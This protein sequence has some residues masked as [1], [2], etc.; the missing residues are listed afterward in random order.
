MNTQLQDTATES[1]SGHKKIIPPLWLVIASAIAGVWS[2]VLMFMGAVIT[3]TTSD[4][5]A[6]VQ[7]LTGY[8]TQGWYI[9]PSQLKDGAPLDV[10]GDEHVYAPIAALFGHLFVWLSGNASDSLPVAD[11]L[12]SYMARHASYGVLAIVGAVALGLMI[13]KALKSWRWGVLAGAALMALPTW[14]GHGMFN[15]KD[16][17]TASA[18]ALWSLGLFLLLEVTDRKGLK[19]NLPGIAALFFGTLLGVGTRPG[20]WTGFA[21]SAF[22]ALIVA[23]LRTQNLPGLR[24]QQGWLYFRN[25]MI[26]FLS[27]YITLAIIYPKAFANPFA[28]LIGSFTESS[29]YEVWTGYTLIGGQFIDAAVTPWYYIPAWVFVTTPIVLWILGL[30]ALVAYFKPFKKRANADEIISEKNAMAVLLAQLLGMSGAAFV[31][32][33]ILYNGVRQLQFMF[34]ALVGLAIMG[35]WVLLHLLPELKKGL[36]A[37]TVAFGLV[38]A[39]LF[40]TVFAQIQLFP[41]GY[42]YFNE[43]TTASKIDNVWPSDYWRSSLRE[44]ITHI[45]K[46]DPAFCNPLA[47]L[48]EGVGNPEGYPLTKYPYHLKRHCSYLADYEGVGT[49]DDVQ[50]LDEGYEYWLAKSSGLGTA[51]PTNCKEKMRITRVNLWQEIVIGQL[52]QCYSQF[53]SLKIGEG[54]QL[55]KTDGTAEYFLDNDWPYA[56]QTGIPF[57]SIENPRLGVQITSE[58]PEAGLDFTIYGTRYVPD[59]ETRTMTVIAN[60]VKLKTFTFTDAKKQTEALKFNVPKSVLTKVR[61]GYLL[62]TLECPNVATVENGKAKVSFVINAIQADEVPASNK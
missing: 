23:V 7:R 13:G 9:Y 41:Y 8:F 40:S 29:Q 32:N 52:A 60:G 15:P 62:L 56:T 57:S 42:S 24:S 45:P 35:L 14:A 46:G 58:I 27:A 17:P 16:T 48:P 10:V 51:L 37:R 34:P 22:I 4:E 31:L 5:T 44:L 2:T 49:A 11:S 54:A 39:T 55:N 59:G 26:G 28:L 36:I 53:Y 38:A 61:P 47:G 25:V 33:S 1:N 30:V 12:A 20:M 6:H 50:K 43:V 3:G 21:V 19:A 18:F